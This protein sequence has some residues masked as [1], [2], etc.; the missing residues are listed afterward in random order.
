MCTL[1]HDRSR[2]PLL[3]AAH[4]FGGAIRLFA[5]VVVLAWC[6]LPFT[7]DAHVADAATS[8]LFPA[9][10]WRL[11]GKPESAD[12][13]SS[14]AKMLTEL[15]AAL[16]REVEDVDA[17]AWSFGGAK[18]TL[19]EGTDE[20]EEAEA[21]PPPSSACDP[22]CVSGQ[23]LCVSGMCLC[24][25][26]FGGSSCATPI[27]ASRLDLAVWLD[28][29]ILMKRLPFLHALRIRTPYLLAVLVWMFFG[30]LAAFTAAAVYRCCRPIDDGGDEDD[31]EL[32]GENHTEKHEVWVQ[33][34]QRTNGSNHAE[35][36]NRFGF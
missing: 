7:H 21:D 32:D 25:H 24:S 30:V 23:G 29:P 22:P 26:P 12:S 35:R 34:K 31:D 13:G 36:K 1:A 2:Q 10:K 20:E 11:S 28:Q 16:A 15:K 33:I 4:C 3:I 5:S 8:K 14:S 27:A 9:R 17:L 19:E 18:G 6:L